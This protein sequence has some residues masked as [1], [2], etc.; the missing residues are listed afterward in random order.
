MICG[1][2]GHGRPRPRSF[3]SETPP[4]H[5]CG[6]TPV[7]SRANST[8]VARSCNEADAPSLFNTI[9]V[10]VPG[11][12]WALARVVVRPR[13]EAAAKKA[14]ANRTRTCALRRIRSSFF[15]LGGRESDKRPAPGISR[16][17]PGGRV[18]YGTPTEVSHS[19]ILPN[20]RVICGTRPS[21]SSRAPLLSCDRL[22][23]ELRSLGERC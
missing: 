7:S 8:P 18:Y 2:R 12:A 16:N 13:D 22:F 10:P 1:N 3:R 14:V 20:T 9:N 5:A 19:I 15:R 6:P 4:P 17:V 23:D 21:L 11:A